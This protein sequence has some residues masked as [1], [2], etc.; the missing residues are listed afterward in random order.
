M[1]GQIRRW[2]CLSL[3]EPPAPVSLTHQ[4]MDV[5]QIGMLG[6]WYPESWEI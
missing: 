2:Y 6:A 4:M 5:P 3:K 1:Y